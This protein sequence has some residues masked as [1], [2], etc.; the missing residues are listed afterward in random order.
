MNQFQPQEIACPPQQIDFY[1]KESIARIRNRL[2]KIAITVSEKT[3]NC[4]LFEAL[5]TRLR[6]ICI[7]MQFNYLNCNP[8]LSEFLQSGPTCILIAVIAY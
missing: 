4:T 2:S 5:E 6:Y 1:L 7:D 8:F 3:R